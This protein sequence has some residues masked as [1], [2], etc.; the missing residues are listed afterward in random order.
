MLSA[1]QKPYTKPLGKDGI[2]VG[3]EETAMHRHAEE[4]ADLFLQNL[5]NPGLRVDSQ[6]TKHQVLQTEENKIILRQIVLA[7]EFV[8]KQ[9]LAF[10]GDRD[11]KVDF[12]RADVN[13][14]NFIATL[15][16]MGKGNSVLY[17]LL[18]LAK[19][20]AK[21]TIQNQ[22][23]HI[24]ACKIRERLTKELREKALPLAVIADEV[25]EPACEP[26]DLVCV[27]KVCGP[28][29]TSRS[30]Y[31][32]VPYQFIVHGESECQRN[33]KKDFRISL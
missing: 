32:G 2:L 14:G 6:L 3:H 1:Y 28:V 19:R 13:R 25:T 17:N 30:S 5:C 16:L 12:T 21:Y 9:G 4:Q 27:F 22:I 18:L 8:A 23:I 29:L 31:Q 15:Q 33:I 7:V 10:R 26:G 20:N 24:Y 11:D